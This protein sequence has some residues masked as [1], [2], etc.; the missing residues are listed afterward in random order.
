MCTNFSLAATFLCHP[1]SGQSRY[2]R[3]PLPAVCRPSRLQSAEYLQWK[4]QAQAKYDRRQYDK[5]VRNVSGAVARE[6]QEG[7]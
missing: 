4:A 6:K 2:A 1:S 7:A 3:T 5:M